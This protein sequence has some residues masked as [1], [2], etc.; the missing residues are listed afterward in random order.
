MRAIKSAKLLVP[1]ITASLAGVAYP[2]EARR[3]VVDGGLTLPIGGY[4]T[5][6][7]GSDCAAQ[8]LPFAITIGGTTYNSFIL[9]GN[10]TLTLGDTAIDWSTVAN[11][12]PSLTGFAM[13]IFSPQMDNTITSWTNAFD[14]QGPAFQETK[15]AASVMSAPGSIT[16]YWFDCTSAIFCGTESLPADLYCCGLT[17][18]E[19]LERQTWNMFGLTLTDLGSGFRL[20]Y[21]YYPAFAIGPNFVPYPVTP[22]G[23]YGFNLPGTASLQATG[24]LVDRSW[25][26]SQAGAVPEP[27]T[28]LTML[29]GFASI[30][31]A[32]RRRRNGNVFARPS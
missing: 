3:T 8:A 9:N 15:W 2:A 28:W 25:T 11:S 14:P 24:S 32:M 27:G 10:G 20:D 6:D 13:P 18:E 19:V 21:F 22:T 16:A 31:F 17:L 1:L 29:V 12:P 23:T 7:G 30:G 26:F 4:C 5:P